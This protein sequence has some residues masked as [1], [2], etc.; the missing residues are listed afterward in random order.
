MTDS[1]SLGIL[2]R[3]EMDLID[4]RSRM[5]NFQ[6]AIENLTAEVRVLKERLPRTENKM[7]D[8]AADAMQQVAQPMI[9]AA[10][11]LKEE[12]KNARKT[13]LLSKLFKKK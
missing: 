12:I 2:E 6:V 4:D 13:S 5:D 9:D 7:K 11:D 1:K 3:I 10:E 8:A